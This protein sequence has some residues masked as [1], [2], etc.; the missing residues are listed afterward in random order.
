MPESKQAKCSS[1][2]QPIKTVVG[3]IRM[4]E[5]PVVCRRCF[6]EQTYAGPSQWSQHSSG[7][8]HQTSEG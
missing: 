3:A 4:T 2:G 5:A 8:A 6:G 7:S 1:C